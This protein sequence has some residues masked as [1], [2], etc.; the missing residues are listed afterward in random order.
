[1]SG[2]FPVNIDTF[3]KPWDKINHDRY[4]IILIYRLFNH[5]TN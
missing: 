2:M 5:F 3:Y 4:I 1:M